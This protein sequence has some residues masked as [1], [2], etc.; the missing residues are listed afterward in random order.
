L[1]ILTFP[2]VIDDV[3]TGGSFHHFDGLDDVG[4]FDAYDEKLGYLLIRRLSRGR[5]SIVFDFCHF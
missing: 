4:M 1:E 2:E 3:D 5:F